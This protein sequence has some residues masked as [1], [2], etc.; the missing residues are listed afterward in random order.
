MSVCLY[1]SL[2]LCLLE[3]GNITYTDLNSLIAQIGLNFV[4]LP[5]KLLPPKG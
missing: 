3:T 2:F 4:I 5:P 1:L